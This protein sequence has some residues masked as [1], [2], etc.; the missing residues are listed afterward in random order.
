MRFLLYAAAL[1]CLADLFL[2]L[3][4]HTRLKPSHF[5]LISGSF[6]SSG[7]S[8]IPLFALTAALIWFF[9]LL[10]LALILFAKWPHPFL[11][12]YREL[13]QKKA[14]ASFPL[15]TTPTMGPKLFDIPTADKPHIL[16]ITLESFRAKNVGCLGA[17]LPLSPHFDELAK[18]GILFSNFHS[19]GNLTNR[20]IIASLFGIQP[21]HQPW[22]LGQYCNLPLIGLP[23]ILSK[24]GYHPALI[25]GGSTA[26]DHEAEF[27]GK[28]G[29]ET[30]LGKR[31]IAKPGTS[32]GSHDEFLMPFAAQWLQKQKTP[33]FL[34]LFTITNHHPWR[35]PQKTD[36]FLNTFAYTDWAL[37]LLIEE[38]RE[39]SLLEKSI[40]FIFGDHGQELEDRDPRFEINRHLFQDNIHIPLLIYAEGRI[41]APLKIDTVSS[42][43]DLLPTVLDL[44]NL[45]DP[46][47]SLGKS[48]LRPSSS[49]I[50]FSHPFDTSIRGCREGNWKFLDSEE[51]YDLSTDPEE[52]INRIAEGTPLK[53]RTEAFFETLDRFY[54][55]QPHEIKESPLHLDFSNSLEMNDAS[56]QKMAQNHTDLSSLTL[57]NCLLLTDKGIA[58]LLNSCP[59]LEKLYLNGIDEITGSGWP[60]IPYLTHLNA[61]NCPQMNTEWIA[62][63]P[64]L[65]ILQLGS[66]EVSDKD[67]IALAETQKNLAAIYFSHLY[68][69][70]DRGLA[71]LLKANPHLVILSLE[72]CPQISNASTDSI[73][74]KIFRYKFISEC[75]LMQNSH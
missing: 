62:K 15:T 34:N 2:R 11:S 17:K 57:S 74:S 65:R 18:K 71:P 45:K 41:K 5:S 3:R 7:K 63:L 13:K 21:A 52:K 19:T 38:L 47:Q 29:F 26:F 44:M 20:A 56:L 55:E 60:P 58:S 39:R 40:L 36:G 46:H 30:I 10:S 14:A 61:M 9:P 35:H 51:L 12:A 37:N 54:S 28:Q 66:S 75:P 8:I 24:H 42:Q 25:Q 1:Y 27:F 67:L 49:P 59:K 73:Q 31:D 70:T 64:S 32:W 43:I 33:T 22:H 53:E 23:H 6:W 16:F 69:I 68:G 4:F 72:N 48:L 50:F